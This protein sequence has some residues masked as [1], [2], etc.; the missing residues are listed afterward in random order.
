M[1]ESEMATVIPMKLPSKR[2]WQLLALVLI[3]RSGREVA[4]RYMRETGESL[5]YGT[6]YAT[7]KKLKERGWVRYSHTEDEDGRVRRFRITASGIKAKQA[8]EAELRRQLEF[9]KK[10]TKWAT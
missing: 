1:R 9:G 5:S 10:A 8:Y 6:V 4:D 2:E 3:E 7:F